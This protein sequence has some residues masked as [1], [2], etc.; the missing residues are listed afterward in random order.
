MSLHGGP[1]EEVLESGP[2]IYAASLTVRP[3]ALRGQGRVSYHLLQ[4]RNPQQSRA[5][6]NTHSVLNR[7]LH[8]GGQIPRTRACG[9]LGPEAQKGLGKNAGSW[10]C[11]SGPHTGCHQAPGSQMEPS[12]PCPEQLPTPGPSAAPHHCLQDRTLPRCCCLVTCF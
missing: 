9:Q 3:A 1:T 5:L 11:E 12:A 8:W 10:S 2:D 7:R 6:A 4:H